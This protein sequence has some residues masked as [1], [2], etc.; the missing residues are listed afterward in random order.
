LQWL[1]PEDSIILDS[2]GW[3]SP[4]IASFHQLFEPGGSAPIVKG[5]AV[6]QRVQG[7][8]VVA[9]NGLTRAHHARRVDRDRN[10]SHDQD[11]RDY[12]HHLEKRETLGAV[13]ASVL[14]SGH[15]MAD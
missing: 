4:Q 14:G 3:D 12:H 13:R 10:G 2:S 15:E 7:E 6:D 8:E 1:D 11:H 9:E 5:E